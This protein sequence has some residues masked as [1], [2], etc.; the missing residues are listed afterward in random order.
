[1]NDDCRR[2]LQWNINDIYNGLGVFIQAFPS[3][4]TEQ[5]PDSYKTAIEALSPGDAVTVFASD[6]IHHPIAL[7]AIQRGIHV[8]N[9][10]PDTNNFEPHRESLAETRKHSAFMYVEHHKRF[11]PAYAD[12]RCQTS[13]QNTAWRLQLLLLVH[14]ATKITAQ[15]ICSL[16]WWRVWHILL[17][18]LASYWYQRINDA[19]PQTREG[20]SIWRQRHRSRAGLWSR[21][22]R[23]YNPACRLDEHQRSA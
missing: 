18:Q 11:D 23:H 12:A 9:T 5:D 21:N 6:P 14:V 22:W 16:G 13:C 10:L 17:L 8:L 19:R 2:H 1:M 4:A 7:Y 3:D 15:A 20:D